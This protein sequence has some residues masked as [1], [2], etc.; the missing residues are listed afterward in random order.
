MKDEVLFPVCM[1][2]FVVGC[3]V[4]GLDN[5]MTLMLAMIFV[6]ALGCALI[7]KRRKKR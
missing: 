4:V 6:S 5:T 7:I 1:G 2:T 3:K